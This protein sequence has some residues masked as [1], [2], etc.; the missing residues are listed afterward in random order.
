MTLEQQLSNLAQRVEALG[1]RLDTLESGATDMRET[2]EAHYEYCESVTGRMMES[3]E[4]VRGNARD[5]LERLRTDLEC[6]IDGLRR[7]VEGLERQA[8]YRY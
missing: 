6:T 2:V 7:E 5:D 1:E 4:R 3:T 8:R